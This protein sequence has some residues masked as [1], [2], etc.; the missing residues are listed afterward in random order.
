MVTQH[1]SA[2]C[3]TSLFCRQNAGVSNKNRIFFLM[4]GLFLLAGMLNAQTTWDGSANNVWNNAANWSAGIPDINDAVII[5]NVANDPVIPAG[6][7]ANAKS[8]N[9]NSG[10]SLTISAS[11][12]LSI[13]GSTGVGMTNN[14]TVVNY[15]TL[16][17]GN[18]TA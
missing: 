6:V 16:A 2:S 3:V 18:I 15:G 1:N 8:V 10:A 11:G 17:L 5:P 7:S 12:S 13:N 4:A 9:V 14:G